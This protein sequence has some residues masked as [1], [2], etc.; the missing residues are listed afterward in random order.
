MHVGVYV[1]HATFLH[2]SV[3]RDRVLIIDE[4]TFDLQWSDVQYSCND[5]SRSLK[6]ISTMTSA[7]IGQYILSLYGVRG[8][9]KTVV[10]AYRTLSS[11][12]GPALTLN[13]VS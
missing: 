3:N 6:V 13:A 4:V 10:W 1:G 9:M 8:A 5:A 11:V 7:R 12:H 2:C